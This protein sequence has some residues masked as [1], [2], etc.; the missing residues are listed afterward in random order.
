V[1]T[2]TTLWN[3]LL[4]RVPAA[5]P[6][7]SQD[8]IR[9][10]FNQL[11]ERRMWTWLMKTNSFYSPM[12]VAGGTVSA[13]PGSMV[14]TGSGTAFISDMLNKQIRIGALGGSSYPTYTINQVTSPLSVVID[15]PWVGPPVT[16]QAYMVF[17]CY[18]PLPLDFQY[19][20][21]V[22]NPTGNYR[23]NHDATQAE[24]D[25]YDPQRSQS[26]ISYAMAYYDT[27]QNSQ[28]SVAGALPV[29]GSGS[30]PVSTT[31]T[32]YTY[33]INSIYSIE[34][35]TGG[36]S[37]VA[38][39]R[40]AQDSGTTSGANVL[41]SVNS[42][43][44]SN[45]VQVYFPAIGTYNLGDVFVIACS[46]DTTTGVPRY[47]MWPRPI[48]SP[49]VYPYQYAAKI[50]ALSDL[51]PQLPNFVARRGD[52][53]LEMALTNCALWPGTADTPNPYR[54]VAAANIHRAN[55]EK[56]IYE[57]EKKD[58]DTA[59]K[60]LSYQNLPFMG[61]WRDGSWLQRHAMYPDY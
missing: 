38:Q 12:Y 35:T 45:G 42:I 51:A 41:T 54:D 29:R 7:L 6:D 16:A 17:Q 20:Y 8:L 44:L 33:P 23:L 50:P 21:S 19:F 52:V 9:D 43:D 59:I 10:A 34:I 40:W 4:L 27:T 36:A 3:R 25:S 57:L 48:G 56:L 13:T 60:D 58:D 15:R 30:V 32:G 55:S 2:F 61:P 5:G 46:A 39:F 1:D 53:L 47:E 49:Y 37:G 18:F 28:G 11:A 24:L 26:G 31:S 22:I 14:I